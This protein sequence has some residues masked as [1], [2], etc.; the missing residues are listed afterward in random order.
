[1][2]ANYQ[3]CFS[4]VIGSEGG[5]QNDP[6]DKGNWTGCSVGKGKN[7]GTNWGI[8]GC[9]YPDLDIKNLKQEDAEQIYYDDY[10]MKASCDD[11]P[12][13]V[14][15]PTFDGSVNSGVSRGVKWLQ[16]A[17]GVAQD[18]VV[19]PVTLNAVVMAD[20]DTTIDRM[21]DARLAYLKGLSTW[22]LYGGG[23]TTRVEKVR[24]DAHKMVAD[25]EGEEPSKQVVS[26]IITAPPGIKIDV[27]VVEDD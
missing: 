27:Q 26:V 8:S 3:E 23:W 24:D 18:G 20:D 4:H 15:L 9:A 19:G 7:I 10:W 13:G 2:K 22:S 6:N 25:H 5:F 21:C 17:V 1:M 12:Y 11:L 14:D 16:G